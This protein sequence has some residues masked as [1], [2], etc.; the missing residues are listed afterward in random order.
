MDY[1]DQKV[2]PALKPCETI[3]DSIS[4]LHLLL[5]S[6]TASPTNLSGPKY[7]FAAYSHVRR[8]FH[9][10]L[11]ESEI[12]KSYIKPKPAPFPHRG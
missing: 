3:S 2:Y 8:E 9:K 5:E 11:K 1:V 10:G 12:Y 4:E 7:S 6:S